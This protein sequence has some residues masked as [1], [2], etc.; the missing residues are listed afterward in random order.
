MSF[1]VGCEEPGEVF[2]CRLSC[3]AGCVF[4]L[5]AITRGSSPCA[6]VVHEVWVLRARA[7]VE[8]IKRKLREV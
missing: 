2:S 3:S 8:P 1:E 5:E 7:A 6:S 4:G